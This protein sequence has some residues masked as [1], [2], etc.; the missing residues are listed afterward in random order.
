MAEMTVGQEGVFESRFF[1]VDAPSYEGISL[2]EFW[3]GWECPYFTQ[4]VAERIM[5]DVR[6]EGIRAY[7]DG[8]TDEF[9]VEGSEGLERYAAT[10]IGGWRWYPTG[11]CRW[12]WESED[13]V[14]AMQ[15][16]NALR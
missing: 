10:L 5:A 8:E 14:G 2:G 16:G 4:D 9:V 11:A 1:V 7:Y 12:G 3:N 6:R 13:D 15:R